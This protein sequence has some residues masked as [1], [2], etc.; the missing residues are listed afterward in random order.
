M[1]TSPRIAIIGSG[2]SGLCLGIRLRQ[3]GIDSFTILE[4]DDR[5]GGTWRDNSYPGA[6]CDVPSMSYCFSF[7]QKTDW[8]RKWAPQAEI[9][10]YMEHCADKYGIRPHIRFG[11]EVMRADFDEGAGLWHIH[12]ADGSSLEAEVLVSG[13]GQLHKP[14]TPPLPG[15][16]RFAGPRFHS[17]RWDHSVDLKGKTVGVIGNAA[18]AIQFIP[19]IAK[20]A[21]RLRIFQRS[22]NWILPRNDRSYRAWEKWAFAHVPGMARLYRYFIWARFESRYPLL[23]GSA[24][25]S[26]QVEKF[27]KQYIRDTIGDADLRRALVPDYPPGARRLLISDDYYQTLRQDHVDLITLGID[28]I[29]PTGVRTRDGRDW[30]VDVLIL[31]TG[32]DSTNF[33]SPIE[34]TGLQGRSLRQEWSLGARAYLGLCVSGFP[35]FFLMY[36]PNTNLGHNSILFMIECQTNYILQC[37]AALRDRG[38]RYLDVKPEA[39]AAFNR[40]LQAE[41]QQ[42][43]WAKTDHSWYKRSDG[44]ITNNW[45]G[46]TTRYW[47]RTRRPDFDAFLLQPRR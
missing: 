3:L 21:A 28:E 29:T 40:A 22:A 7:E 4:K 38:L 23:R 2:F 1:G 32:F 17:A 45:S 41:L 18:S 42:T 10:Q 13:V 30:P 36:G 25:L 8:S 20:S 34:L 16:D 44:T 6:A 35:N 37:I 9:L 11:A 31:A 5:L 24:F 14:Y 27:V 15:L 33:L 46:T 43:A 26:R 39:Q 12:L 19:E 47:W